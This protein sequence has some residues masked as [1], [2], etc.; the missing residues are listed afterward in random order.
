MY[1]E[2]QVLLRSYAT[3]GSDGRQVAHRY[4]P[5]ARHFPPGPESIVTFFRRS[6]VISG[7]TVHR[8]NSASLRTN[9]FD[10]TLLYQLYLVGMLMAHGPGLFLPDALALV[11]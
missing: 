6:I 1:P 11:R 8:D 3:V 5:D 4:F 2:I 10:G 9:R 7:L